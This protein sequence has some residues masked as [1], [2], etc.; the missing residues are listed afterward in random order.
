MMARRRTTTGVAVIVV[1]VARGPRPL[2]LDDIAIAAPR[3]KLRD[4][5]RLYLRIGNTRGK[6]KWFLRYVSKVTRTRRDLGLGAFPETS[7][8]QARVRADAARKLLRA[9]VD[10]LQARAATVER[11]RAEIAERQSWV[12]P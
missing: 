1:R 4:A 8:E 5:D 7:I 3:S 10:P 9:G 12:A 6:G 2:T 11:Q